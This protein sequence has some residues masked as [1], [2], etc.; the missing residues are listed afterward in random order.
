V[1]ADRLRRQAQSAAVDVGDRLAGRHRDAPVGDLGGI[2][3][4]GAGQSARDERSSRRVRPIGEGFVHDGQ[5]FRGRQP[6]EGPSRQT[7]QWQGAVVVEDGADDGG[8]LFLVVDDRVVQRPVR[9]DV[10]DA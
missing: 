7:E 5:P 10:S 6:E 2:M 4:D 8:S 1:D 9:L 3:Q